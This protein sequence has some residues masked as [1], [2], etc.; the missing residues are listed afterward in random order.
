MQFARQTLLQILQLFNEAFV[1]I[2]II[3]SLLAYDAIILVLLAAVVLPVFLVFYSSTKKK[4]V[5]I[6]KELNS[7]IPHINK[8]IF[9]LAFGYV[10]VVIGGVIKFFK[11]KYTSQI[12][13]AKALRVKLLLIQ[14]IPNRLIEICVMLAVIIIVV[15]GVYTI[16]NR[17]SVVVLIS[18][19]GLASYRTVP[20][21]NRLMASVLSI[22]GQEYCLNILESFLKPSSKEDTN[23]LI[24]ETS[25]IVFKN[26][27]S[28]QNLDFKFE[29]AK[30]NVIE[31]LNL[32]IKKG[33][34]IGLS[35]KSGSGKTTLMNLML[36]F[37]QPTS[38]EIRID[39][40]VLA[41]KNLVHWQK[42]IGY[43][44]QD[45]FLID[46]SLTENVAFGI[47]ENEIDQG[48]VNQ[49]IQKAQLGAVVKELEGGLQGQIGERG[50]K[51][52]GGQRQRVGIARAL[53]H[54]AEVL[55]F[56]EAT[57]ALDT[58]TEEEITQSIRHLQNEKITMV[59][60][61]HRPSTLR[62][63][64]KIYEVSKTGLIER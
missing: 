48:K 35:G 11:T 31:N 44:R 38:G 52:S 56:D 57:S 34:T 53:Y 51:L 37:L 28:I 23:S 6:N 24:N 1:L 32:K 16:E 12:R 63:C 60:I 21:I 9:E 19:F 3:S 33:E 25:A 50:N 39:N 42:L 62:Y 30:K 22:K 29:D 45:V 4:V 47:P 64:D 18:I 26:E 20:S 58:E 27:I 14:N 17:S 36:G 5:E 43:V 49:V 41:S 2:L 8:P 59:I 13:E 40:T 55:F 10:D 46:G 54:G 61:A 7:M 15:Y